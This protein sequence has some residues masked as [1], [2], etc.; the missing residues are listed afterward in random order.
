MLSLRITGH[1]SQHVTE[2]GK[3]I[4]PFN[5]TAVGQDKSSTIAK[6]SCILSENCTQADMG[7]GTYPAYSTAP[8]LAHTHAC[9]IA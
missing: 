1:F 9:I 3:Q 4:E 5:G 7:D 6:P 2:Q 8:C